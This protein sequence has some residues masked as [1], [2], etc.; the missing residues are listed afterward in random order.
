VSLL[1]V[2]TGAALTAVEPHLPAGASSWAFRGFDGLLALTFATTGALLRRK[3]PASLVG[4]LLEA[5][6]V[7]TAVQYVTGEYAVAALTRSRPWPG[8]EAAAWVQTWEW[9]VA[10]SLATTFLFLRYPDGQL[11]SARWRGVER[12]MAVAVT[13]GAAAQAIKPGRI[14]NL[15]FVDNPLGAHAAWVA[16]AAGVGMLAF[17]LSLA[18]SAASLFARRRTVDSVVRAQLRWL[19]YSASVVAALLL[20]SGSVTLAAGS[21][22]G[23]SKSLQVALVV[24]VLGLPVSICIAVTRYRLFD[25]DRLVSRTVSYAAVTAVLVGVYVGVVVLATRVLPFSSS[26]GVAASTL[27][28]AALFSPLRRS[29]QGAVDGWFNRSRYDAARIVDAFAGRVR[30]AVTVE[31]IRA[32]LGDVVDRTMQPSHVS[33]WIPSAEVSPDTAG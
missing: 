13:A 15:A 3:V 26:F 6:G 10:M 1:L 22:G 11:P 20:V 19:A 5:S 14:E 33:V 7:F 16:P 4:R 21:H 8:G 9:V 28:A 27:I 17:S 24:S 29:V 31:L 30:E 25:I 12:A 18:I 32:H 23:I 2:S